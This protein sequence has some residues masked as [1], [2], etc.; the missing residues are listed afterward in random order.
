MWPVAQHEPAQVLDTVGKLRAAKAAL[1]DDRQVLELV[2]EIAPEPN[3]RAAQEQYPACRVRMRDV[4]G[5]ERG[6]GSVPLR[7]CCEG[8]RRRL[9]RRGSIE[10][11]AGEGQ[12][13]QQV[14][15]GH[16]HRVRV[17]AP[18]SSGARIGSAAFRKDTALRM[19]GPVIDAALY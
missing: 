1:D 12:G 11:G 5:G 17:D 4:I 14:S 8:R 10:C 3:R 15:K 7:G 16:G 6:E 9:A 13:E 18:W 2:L 19:P